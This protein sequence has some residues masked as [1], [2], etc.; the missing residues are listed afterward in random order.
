MPKFKSSDEKLTWIGEEL[1]VWFQFNAIK[2]YNDL[3]LIS[4][5]YNR[6]C[7]TLSQITDV[8]IFAEFSRRIG[9]ETKKKIIL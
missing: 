8:M 3:I 9:W 2:N 4:K 6:S 7:D 1:K 5:M